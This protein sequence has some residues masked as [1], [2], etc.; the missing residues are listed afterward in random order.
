MTGPEPSIH[1]EDLMKDYIP[2]LSIDC[3][4]FGFHDGEL[5]VLLL[6][7]K[8]DDE[9]AL[10]GGYVHLHESVEE[11]ANHTLKMRT[12]LENVFLRQFH[13]FSHPARRRII[14]KPELWKKLGLT[15]YDLAWVTKRFI[16]I[17]FY[18]LV[19]YTK[20][21]ATPDVFS[22]SSE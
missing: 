5:K 2:H 17:G 11:A 14:S 1:K 15:D 8:D 7:L 6:K 3:V 16:T 9:W 12:G 13:I 20:A 18:A 4:V 19:E 10:P 21:I 22:V